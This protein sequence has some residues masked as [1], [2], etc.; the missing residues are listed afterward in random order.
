MLVAL[1]LLG[2]GCGGQTSPQLPQLPPG[3]DYGD[4]PGLSAASDGELREELAQIAKEGGTPRQLSEP[5]AADADNAAAGL[6]DLFPQDRLESIL[7]ESEKLFPAGAFRLNPVEL[8]RVIHFRKRHDAARLRARQALQ[9]PQCDFGIDFASG[10]PA[11]V[12]FIAVVR[13]CARL[14]AFTAAEALADGKPGAAVESLALM[15]RLAQ[16]LGAQRH[17][18]ARLEAAFLRAEAFRLLQAIVLDENIRQSD[19]QRLHEIV[20]MHLKAWVDDADA[21]IGDRAM[22]M[23]AYEMVR[24]GRLRE[25]LTLRE[26]DLFAKEGR[27]KELLAAAQKNVDADELYYLQTM[28]QIIESCRRPYYRRTEL[29]D[30]IGEDLQR[31]RNTP[32]FPVV[33]ARLLLP[34]IRKGHA[35]QARDRANWEAWA[36]ALALATGES[37]PQRTN[38]LSGENYLHAKQGNSIIVENFGSS[39]D[40]DYPS[41]SVPC[42]EGAE[43]K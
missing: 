42:L 26:L 12:K 10:F 25:L 7:Q 20:G 5:R 13:I 15:L 2:A 17:V 33:A 36:L 34:D 21:W 28:R 41:I 6:S 32:G 11:E 8:Q 16:C 39:Q 37:P 18:E 40:G 35:I 1:C 3:A 29:F 38:P 14:E 4:L 24:D 27:L 43:S 23:H 19:L 22:G 30:S 31:R 9:R